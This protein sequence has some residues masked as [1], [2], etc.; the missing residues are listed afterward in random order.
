[1][2]WLQQRDEDKRENEQQKNNLESHIFET[3]DKMYTEDVMTHSTDE[4]RRTILDALKVA[5]DWLEDE[6]YEAETET[7]RQKFRE[8]KRLSRPVFRR[9]SEALKRPRLMEELLSSLNRSYGMLLYM[10]NM[11]TEEE[12]F[13]KV[14][15]KTLEDLTYET[16]VSRIFCSFTCSD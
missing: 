5:R 15:I 11:T 9:L 14:E 10:Q 3:Q 1:M 2:N 4:E 8:L 12:I 7:Y 13:T 16:F 6:G